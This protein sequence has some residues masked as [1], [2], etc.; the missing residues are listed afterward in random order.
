MNFKAAKKKKLNR[1]NRKKK[2]L[3]QKV[4]RRDLKREEDCEGAEHED[5]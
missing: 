3:I 5:S 2:Q 1:S 4:I